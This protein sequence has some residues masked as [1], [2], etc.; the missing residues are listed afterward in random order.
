MQ[1]EHLPEQGAGGFL[2][3][4]SEMA[5]S[6]PG[7]CSTLMGKEESVANKVAIFGDVEKRPVMALLWA[8]TTGIESV[9]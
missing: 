1:M 6:E 8:I 3:A 5:M 7:R 4:W 2:E 9:K